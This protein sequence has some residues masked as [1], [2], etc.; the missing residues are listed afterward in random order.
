M[1]GE[2]SNKQGRGNPDCTFLDKPKLVS[3][4]TESVGGPPTVDTPQRET[5]NT[6]GVQSASSAT[7]KTEPV[8]LL[9]MRQIYKDRGF[10]EKATNIILPSWC[11]SSPK[12]FDGHIRKWLSFCSQRQVDPTRPSVEVAVEFLTTLYESGLSNS[13]INSARSALSAILDKPDSA[14]PTFGEHPDVKCFMK[15]VFQ[16]RPPLPGYSKT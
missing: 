1:S 9:F 8:S 11:Q 5:A 14:Q 6:A 15:G 4:A 3:Q 2:N 10:S 12:Q 13:S 7:E 16:N